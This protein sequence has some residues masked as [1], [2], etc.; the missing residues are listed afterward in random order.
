VL[1]HRWIADGAFAN[2]AQLNVRLWQESFATKFATA[3][4]VACLQCM[5]LS[6]P[7]NTFGQL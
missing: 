3:L 5:L 1:R 6:S 7:A 4:R 2:F